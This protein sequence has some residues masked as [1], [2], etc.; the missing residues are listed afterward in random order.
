VTKAGKRLAWFLILTGLVTAPARAELDLRN[1]SVERLGNGLTVILLE[2]RNFPVVSVQMLYRVGARNE[3]TGLTGLAHFLEHMAFR[4]SANFPGTGLVSSIYALGGEWHGYT[5]TDETT[6]FATVPREHLDLLL[7]IEADRM[8]R[9]DI[10]PDDI[11]AERGAV[12]AEMHMYEND[13]GSLLIDA[14]M[15]ASFEAHPY[16]NNTIGFESDIEHVTHADV[17]DFYRRHYQPANA[18]LAI[19]G[20]FDRDKVRIRIEELFGGVERGTATPLPHTLEPPQDGVRRI[21]VSGTTDARRFG[22]AYRA[23]AASHPDYPAFLVLQALLGGASGVSFLQNDWGSAVGESGL[24]SGAA[25]ELTTWFPPSAQDYVF[26]ISGALADDGDEAAAEAAVEY[27]LATSRTALVAAQSLE[28][29]IA[30]VH[31]TLVFDVA[32][33]EDAAHQ[34]AYFEGLGALDVLLSLPERVAAV[35]AAD[36]RRVA[37]TWLNPWQRTIAWY[38]PRAHVEVTSAAGVERPAIAAGPAAPLDL[39]P[40]PPARVDSLSGGVPVIVQRSDVSPAVH[41]Q[42]VLPGTKLAGAAVQQDAPVRGYSSLAYPLRPAGLEAGIAQAAADLVS[43]RYLPRTTDGESDDPETRLEQVFDDLMPDAAERGQVVPALIV[44]S[45]DVDADGVS[46]S[47]ERHFGGLVR[48]RTPLPRAETIG[49]GERLISLGRPVAQASL[50]YIVT[51]PGPGDPAHAAW[52]LLLY[53]VSHG[54]EGRL[55][56]EAI[57]KRG[58]AYYIDGQYRSDGTN[59][60]ITLATGVDPGKVDALRQLQAEVLKD[61][62][63]HPPGTEEVAE[64]KAYL[65]GRAR[66]AAQSN[67]ELA[68]RYA[69]QWLWYGELRSADDLERRLAAVDRQGVVDAIPAF[70]DGLTIVVER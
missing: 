64:A 53:I 55:G 23:P 27:R 28:A 63:E 69:E 50:G 52:Q 22:I 24:L 17:V 65:V 48:S 4:S 33:T 9:L 20:D 32:T 51:A 29:A 7:R 18:V 2:D 46:A 42:L 30:E 62:G 37:G 49:S 1:A 25:E 13:P 44:V 61:L 6:Y 14:L 40:L 31:D 45:G 11:E 15:F 68:A 54:Y 60:W 56:V 16:R 12:L 70:V 35:T 41:L 67:A 47:L 57:S 36:V 10:S 21:R 19:V 38:G 5:W 66:S 34:L 3:V 8:T 58:L 26:V 43:M 39:E 59:G